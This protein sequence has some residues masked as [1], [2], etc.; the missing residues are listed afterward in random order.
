MFSH[1]DIHLLETMGNQAAVAIENAQLYENLKKSEANMR[2]ADRLAALGTLTAGLAHEI[3]NPLVA[4]KT[5]IQLLPQRFDDKEFR[6][7]FLQI[8]AGEVDRLSYLVTEL[9]DFARPSQPN[10][11]KEDINNVADKMITLIKTQAKKKNLK[12][13]KRFSQDTPPVMIDK[14]QIKQVL[15]NL[16]LNAIDA[17]PEN[18]TITFESRLISK[19]HENDYVQVEVRDTGKGIPKDDIEQ[20]F[21][22]FF[23]TK[24]EG[25]GLGL[26]ISYRIVEEHSGYMEVESNKDEGTSFYVNLPIEPSETLV[27]HMQNPPTF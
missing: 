7:H 20:I 2:R 5:F 17:T 12:I 13:D 6:E 15:L 26:P 4:I 9:L 19:T 3:R 18:G 23:T 16:F 1:E 14:E 25:S 22:P 24:N 21:T 11:R 10:L 8:T 27:P